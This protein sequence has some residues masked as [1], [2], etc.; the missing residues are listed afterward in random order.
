MISFES[1][2]YFGKINSISRIIK[3]NDDENKHYLIKRYDYKGN[4]KS[5][6]FIIPISLKNT[7]EIIEDYCKDVN[8]YL[9]KYE[10]KY[11]EY[12]NKK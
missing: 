7:K 5:E 9:I 4:E 8:D 12:K 3:I 10:T 11:I 6:D 1:L 2:P